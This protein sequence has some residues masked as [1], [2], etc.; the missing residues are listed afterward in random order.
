MIVPFGIPEEIEPGVIMVRPENISGV[1]RTFLKPDGSGKIKETEGTSAKR[2]LGPSRGLP[3]VVAPPN[4]LLGLAITEGIEDAA[5]VHQVTGLGAWAAGC[6]NRLP[7]L[8]EAVPNFIE[9]V[10]IYAHDDDDGKRFS[11]QLAERLVSRTEV[12]IEGIVP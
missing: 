2:M 4:D 6:A 1:H 11:L 12:F 9:T 10:T 3:L 7:G 5:S 8:A